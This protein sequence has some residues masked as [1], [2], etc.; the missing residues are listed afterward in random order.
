LA[1]VMNPL[2]VLLYCLLRCHGKEKLGS[3]C[4]QKICRTSFFSAHLE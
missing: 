1:S 4:V 3:E 2:E